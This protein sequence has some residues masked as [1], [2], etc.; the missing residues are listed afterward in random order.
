MRQA[1][2]RREEDSGGA[3]KVFEEQRWAEFLSDETG[4]VNR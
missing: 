3:R 4:A 1:A 2:R